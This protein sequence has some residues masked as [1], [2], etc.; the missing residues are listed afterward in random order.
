MAV[1]LSFGDS[2]AGLLIDG[3][4]HTPFIAA[5]LTYTESRGIKVEV[6]Y[7]HGAQ[8]DQF[9]EPDTWFDTAAP[10]RNLGFVTRGGIISLFGCRYSGHS[11]AFG[12][13][14][15]VGVIT[16][17][18]VVLKSN[19]GDFDSELKV[20]RLKSEI[21]GIAEWSKLQSL[22]Y[23]PEADESGRLTKFTLTA[24]SPEKFRWIQGGATLTI[25][26]NW[27]TFQS[28]PGISVSEWGSLESEF[29]E[30]RTIGEHLNEQR[31]IIALL[32][33][34]F[35]CAIRFRRHDVYDERFAERDLSGRLIGH[36][37]Y[38]LVSAKTFRDNALP[39]L[40]KRASLD[41][42]A[43]M[44]AIGIGGLLGW[45][46][47][48][49]KWKRAINPAVSALSRSGAEVETLAVNAA[50]SLE[51]AGSL[52]GPMDGEP[53]A[54]NGGKPTMAAFVFRCLASS[55]ID[56]SRVSEN[57][58]GLARAISTNYNTIKH[59]DRGEFPRASETYFASE[60]SLLTIRVL[61]ANL[62][63]FGSVDTPHFAARRKLD[64]LESICRLHDL[65]VDSS[66]CFAPYPS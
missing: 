14:Y 53:G 21:D 39:K 56:F 18:S 58:A 37:Y 57:I 46:S 24:E 48:H 59:F 28:G 4:D 16:P 31:K 44:D 29:S 19:G 50:I 55:G 66:G 36:S 38:S 3:K 52:I 25:A 33:L 11:M 62:A 47:V 15:S 10:P 26:N 6:P 23:T 2:L 30:P 34:V 40:E 17:E 7:V 42:I 12:H 13:G 51:A 9:S 27:E 61:V 54:R 49:E 35:G 45:N 60:V 20:L 63:K 5:T 64:D 1:K 41:V 8:T 43:S 65:F 22:R 32:T